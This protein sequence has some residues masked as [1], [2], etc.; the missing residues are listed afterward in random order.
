[1]K[2]KRQKIPKARNPFVVAAKFRVAGVHDK[3]YKSKRKSEKQ[4]FTEFIRTGARADDGDRLLICSRD[5]NVG[6]NP[7]RFT[8]I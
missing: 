1:M 4:K 2:R 5:A 6:S 3:P 8:I 7:S